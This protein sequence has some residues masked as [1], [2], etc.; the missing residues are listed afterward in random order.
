[1]FCWPSYSSGKW[2][3]LLSLWGGW[4][5]W[6]LSS[7]CTAPLLLCPSLLPSLVLPPFWFVL[8]S[9]FP[10]RSLVALGWR[11]S[12]RMGCGQAFRIQGQKREQRLSS[13]TMRLWVLPVV[14]LRFLPDNL[15]LCPQEANPLSG[16]HSGRSMGE[17]S[18]QS[19]HLVPKLLF[20]PSV[21]VTPPQ[22]RE[23]LL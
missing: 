12:L 13:P 5:D 16:H 22:G 10:V 9:T 7:S 4:G 17:D 19:F 11:A 6:E 8:V 2:D 21:V 18:W 1:M 20:S 14:L 23:L 3:L 15:F